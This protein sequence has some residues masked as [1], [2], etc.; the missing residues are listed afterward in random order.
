MSNPIVFDIETRPG[1]QE[2]I[3]H[4]LPPFDPSEVKV[5]NMKDPAL[6]A[7]KI[8]DAEEKHLSS[9][10][11]KAALSPDSGRV[12]AIGF[13]WDQGHEII[14]ADSPGGEAKII[15]HF[16]QIFNQSRTGDAY[17]EM[18]GHNIIDFDLPFLVARS[19]AL[20]IEVPSLAYKI[21]RNGKFIAWSDNFIDTRLIFMMNRKEGRSSLDAVSR[22]F[23]LGGKDQSG[24][25]FWA[26]FQKDR[27]AAIDYLKK[28]LDLTWGVAKKMGLIS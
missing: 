3:I 22:F 18:I 24:K 21:Q 1:D 25:D 17:Q 20:G 16:W 2:E 12:V 15:S 6:I 9:F 19:W 11:E 7:A 8:K 23:G 14:S 5:G 27:Q 13:I 26:M 4:L 10:L 28:D